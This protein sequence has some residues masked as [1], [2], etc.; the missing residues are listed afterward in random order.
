MA[1]QPRLLSFAVCPRCCGELR[2]DGGFRLNCSACRLSYPI[3]DNV[4]H[5]VIDEATDL[6]TGGRGGTVAPD[7]AVRFCEKRQGM[8]ARSFYLEHGTCKVIG[9]PSGDTNKTAIMNMDMLLVLDEGTKGIVQQYI[10]KQFGSVADVTTGETGHFRR[11][12]DVVIEDSSVSRLHAIVF[13]DGIKVGVLDLVSKN[14][15]FING[16]EVESHIL[17]TGD[18]IEIGDTK[19][20]YEG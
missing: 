11:S 7:K 3:R 5:L 20:V 17:K 19:L 1:I 12:S 8:A 15:T 16:R 18:V 6:R 13:Y 4:P 14:G 9:R 2:D 10:R